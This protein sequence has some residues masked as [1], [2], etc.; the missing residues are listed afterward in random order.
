MN[1]AIADVIKNQNRHW[2]EI[3]NNAACD[4]IDVLSRQF[5]NSEQD[6]VFLSM[7]EVK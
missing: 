1:L 6:H 3:K 5:T 2:F 7:S 4:V